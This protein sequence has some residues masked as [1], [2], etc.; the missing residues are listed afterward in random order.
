MRGGKSIDLS[1]LSE[2]NPAEDPANWSLYESTEELREECQKGEI[3]KR[4]HPEF[5]GTS[6]FPSSNEEATRE[7]FALNVIMA[8]DHERLIDCAAHH[9]ISDYV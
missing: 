2:P 8:P 6:A 4:V 1:T 7:C 3:S 5:Q 9:S